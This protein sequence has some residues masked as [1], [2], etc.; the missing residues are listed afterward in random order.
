MVLRGSVARA[1]VSAPTPI[2]SARS[3]SAVPSTIPSSVILTGSSGQGSWPGLLPMLTS[4][5]PV[6]ETPQGRGARS[7]ASG[8]NLA[9]S[10]APALSSR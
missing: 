4:S 7:R 1:T 9:P 8:P 5:T 10:I 3:A 2:T 6:A